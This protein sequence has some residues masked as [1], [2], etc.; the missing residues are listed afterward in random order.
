MINIDGAG[1]RDSRTALS[2]YNLPEN[3]V[4]EIM[5]TSGRFPTLVRGEEWYEG[6][7]SIFLQQGVS[8][9]AVTSSNLHEGV[10][11]IS[12][13]PQDTLD[14]VDPALLIELAAF[15]SHVTSGKIG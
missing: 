5:E 4:S 9:M 14:Q 7:H 2:F 3:R 11:M 13:T 10:M 1:Y 6:D 15:L 8:C 12:H